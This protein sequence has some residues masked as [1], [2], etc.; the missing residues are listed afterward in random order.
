MNSDSPSSST[1]VAEVL[2]EV[3]FKASGAVNT[4]AFYMINRKILSQDIDRVMDNAIGKIEVVLRKLNP[5]EKN[6][7]KEEI[8]D[9]H[10]T[11]S[12][13]LTKE[14]VARV[15]YSLPHVTTF[16]DEKLKHSIPVN[17]LMA[18]KN[19]HE[20]MV[21]YRSKLLSEYSKKQQDEANTSE[22]V[23]T[24]FAGRLIRLIKLMKKVK[25]LK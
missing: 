8:Q 22:L 5:D 11:V 18:L 7:A 10:L 4:A 21:E 3:I 17:R 9:G 25:K 20:K 19:L 24:F 15:F 1:D 13:E 23:F 12:V 6:K 2:K 16:C 14:D